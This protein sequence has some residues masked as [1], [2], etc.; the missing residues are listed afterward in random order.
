MEVEEN[1]IPDNSQPGPE[2]SGQST[3]KSCCGPGCNCS[4]PS[5]GN[6]IKIAA[7]LIIALIAIGIFAFKLIKIK[8]VPDSGSAY[9]A[10]TD[11]NNTNTTP[12]SAEEP[13]APSAAPNQVSK[14][15]MVGEYLESLNSLN[16]VAVNQDA[17]FIL[18]PVKD[19]GT[20]KQETETAMAGA[21]RTL[22]SKG[23]NVGLYTLRTSAEDYQKISS[24]I[25]IPAILVACKG[26]GMN[27]VPGR[28]V[29]ETKLLQAFVAVSQAGGCCGASGSGCK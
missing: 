9:T 11:E 13:N 14:K 21:Q 16:T 3:E 23:V 26:R 17:V 18:I 19:K 27:A 25:S 6:K 4:K 20:V 8:V 15:V 5:S 29:T 7:G 1:K 10:A 28:D 22:K 2:S 12:P 24:Q